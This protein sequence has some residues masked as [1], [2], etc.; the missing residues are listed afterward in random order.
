MFRTVLNRGQ[1]GSQGGPGII[2]QPLSPNTTSHPQDERIAAVS[3]I[4][5]NGAPDACLDDTMLSKGLFSTDERLTRAFM[6]VNVS[7][8]YPWPAIAAI[9]KVEVFP[10]L[11]ALSHEP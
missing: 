10:F 9:F 5:L 8:T 6:V 1:S 3:Q 11:S 7:R 4:S 2:G